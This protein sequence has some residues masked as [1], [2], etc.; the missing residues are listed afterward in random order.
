MEQIS[1]QIYWS[2]WRNS[3][4]SSITYWRRCSW[5][6]LQW[7]F[8]TTHI[9]RTTRSQHQNLWCSSYCT[10]SKS[11]W[12]WFTVCTIWCSRILYC[13][14]RRET[15]AILIHWN[16]YRVLH[17]STRNWIWT[18]ETFWYNFTRNP[19]ICRATI[20]NNL[21]SWRCKRSLYSTT[22]WFWFTV[23]TQWCCRSSWIQSTRRSTTIQVYWRTYR[24]VYRESSRRRNRDQTF[25]R[26]NSSDSHLRRA[27]IRCQSLYL[28]MPET[29]RSRPFIGSGSFRKLSGAAESITIQPRREANALLLYWSITNENIPSPMLV[30][31]H[32]SD[33]AEVHSSTSRLT[34]WQ[35]NWNSLE[36]SEYLAKQIQFTLQ[37][38]LVLVHSG[39][40]WCSR[41]SHCQSRRETNALL[42]YR[43][44]LQKEHLFS[45]LAR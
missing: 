14:S 33:F 26:Y 25:W 17:S 11:Y 18:C 41:I 35:P 22:Y 29:P 2:C 23:C 45:M 10:C 39:S 7:F 38:N 4:Y 5:I 13:K 34:T 9:C 12:F 37:Y 20:R 36:Q 43:E 16:S 32:Q 8:R 3:F 31:I 40:I 42:V 6:Q 15:T 28:E 19:Y 24:S 21:C 1:L 44:N 27:T 30:W